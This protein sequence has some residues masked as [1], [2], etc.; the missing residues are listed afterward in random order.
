MAYPEIASHLVV[1]K[2]ILTL[3]QVRILL[4]TSRD[5]LHPVGQVK[6]TQIFARF[7]SGFSN[8]SL[9]LQSDPRVIESV[10][11]SAPVEHLHEIS[12][13]FDILLTHQDKLENYN[14][15]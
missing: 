5:A 11:G 14:R 2:N 15:S 1:E 3:I 9:T 10:V 4:Q 6:L 13:M 12:N 8:R 7:F